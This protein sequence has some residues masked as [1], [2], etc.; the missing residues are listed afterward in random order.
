MDLALRGV[1]G[2]GRRAPKVS[3]KEGARGVDRMATVFY[4]PLAYSC[5]QVQDGQNGK[6]PGFQIVL[7]LTWSDESQ[8]RRIRV[9]NSGM[10]E[11]GERKG[12]SEERDG[13]RGE[14]GS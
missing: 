1:C 7:F 11:Q 12:G 6:Y 13:G 3:L 2:L 8:S 14:G 10:C 4:Y 9:G 5:L